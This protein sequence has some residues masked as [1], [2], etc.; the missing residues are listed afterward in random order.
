[1]SE[2]FCCQMTE[3]PPLA[4]E[5]RER[6]CKCDIRYG[7]ACGLWDLL[8]RV[9]ELEANEKRHRLQNEATDADFE[10]VGIRV[11]DNGL[12][13]NVRAD[14]FREMLQ[15]FV[16]SENAI[17][18]AVA[19]HFDPESVKMCGCNGCILQRQFKRAKSLLEEA[20]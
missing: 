8:K 6:R 3:L 15:F 4:E 16:N 10:R 1:M 5:L 2:I 9:A 19:N 12:L 20:V 13:T 18:P 7:H 11:E 14:K 17:V